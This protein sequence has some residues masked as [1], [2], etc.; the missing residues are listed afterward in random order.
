MTI[1]FHLDVVSAEAAI[2]SGLVQKLF[3]SGIMGDLEILNG[4]A[5]LL[6]ALKPGPVWIVKQDGQEEVFY[7]SGG[8]LEAQPTVTTILSD[9]AIRAKDVDETQ[10]LEAKK[11]AEQLLAGHGK[12]FDY[13]TAQ[14]QLLEA[15]AQLKALKK[16]REKHL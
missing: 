2:F 16:F 5:P 6:T 13:V 10:A 9:T 8:M 14:S 15:V 11:R 4:H 12:D 3:V 7:I 1:S